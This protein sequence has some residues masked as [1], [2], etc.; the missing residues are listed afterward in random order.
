M[1]NVDATAA[2]R[3]MAQLRAL[4]LELELDEEPTLAH[5]LSLPG[6]VR[7]ESKSVD[8]DALVEEARRAFAEALDALRASHTSLEVDEES[9]KE[10]ERFDSLAYAEALRDRLIEAEPIEEAA[11]VELGAARRENTR[12]AV[13]AAAENQGKNPVLLCSDRL[14][15][16]IRRL[17][18]ST[19]PSL[20]VISFQ[21]LSPHLSLDPTGVIRVDN[22]QPA[23]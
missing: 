17:L 13:V 15:P 18:A 12:V 6:V 21:E 16:V 20:P 3:L 8:D 10:V 23:V 9:G 5:V 7:T 14:R 1:M 11:L 4:R 19:W 22:H 2:A